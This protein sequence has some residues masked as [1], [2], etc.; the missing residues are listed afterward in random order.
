[1]RPGGRQRLDEQSEA[2]ALGVGGVD[3]PTDFIVGQ[4]HVARPVGVGKAL[5]ADLPRLRGREARIMRSREIERGADRARQ[6]IDGGGGEIVDQAVAPLPP[7]LGVD[8]GDWLGERARRAS[9]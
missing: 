8:Q 2:V 5:Q 9:T 6:A 3:Q 7:F 4:D 1:M